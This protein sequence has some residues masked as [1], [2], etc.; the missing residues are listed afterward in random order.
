MVDKMAVIHKIVQPSLIYVPY[1]HFCFTKMINS[2]NCTNGNKV[3]AVDDV[4]AGDEV[5]QLTKLPPKFPHL[6]LVDE[7]KRGNITTIVYNIEIFLSSTGLHLIQK[8]LT[9]DD[10]KIL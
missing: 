1:K 2:Y 10:F 9:L 8:Y 3:P 4:L 7:K 5:P 6:I